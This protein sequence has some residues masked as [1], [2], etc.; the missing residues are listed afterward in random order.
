MMQPPERL[1][2]FNWRSIT[3]NPEK[4][5]HVAISQYGR[6]YVFPAEYDVYIDFAP[7]KY[8]ANNDEEETE[9]GYFEFKVYHSKTNPAPADDTT[10]TT[11]TR[12]ETLTDPSTEET[13]G[14]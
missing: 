4:Q 8:N 13:G 2:D 6:K 3:N 9:N 14:E 5:V 10:W 7:Q 11:I 12:L 1:F